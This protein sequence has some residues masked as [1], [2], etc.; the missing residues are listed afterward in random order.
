M[1]RLRAPIEL[2][3]NGGMARDH[4]IDYEKMV[5]N[6]S[7]M[8]S[9]I[10]PEDMLH[11]LTSPPEIYLAEGGMTT[12]TGNT[13]LNN[14]REENIEIINN[15][16]NRIMVSADMPLTYQ[17]RTYI[18]DVLRKVGIRDDRRFMSEVRQFMQE[19]RDTNELINI[20][21]S[22]PGQF[23][24]YVENYIEGE[25]REREDSGEEPGEREIRNFLAQS[26]LNR[27][28]TGAIYQILA[29]FNRSINETSIA[30]GEIRISE[31]AY[32]AQQILL[33]RIREAAFKEPP[34]LVYKSENV[35]EEEFSSEQRDEKNLINQVNSAV[36]L[37][38]IRNLY[39]SEFDRIRPGENRWFEFKEVLYNTSQNTIARL[40]G[41]TENVYVSISSPQSP[42]EASIT[43]REEE[44]PVPGEETRIINEGDRL[45][46][47][48]K[49]VLS[50]TSQSTMT[51]LQEKTENAY[52]NISSPEFTEEASI[53]L[54]EEEI[55]APGEE[56]RIISEDERLVEEL[57]RVERINQQ[58]VGRYH[59][60]MEL[61]SRIRQ[62]E[63]KTGGALKT[64]KASLGALKGSSEVLSRLKGEE[65]EGDRLRREVFNEV[66]KLFPDN[67]GQI[68]SVIEQYI[69]EGTISPDSGMSIV[70]NDLSTL[71]ADIERAEHESHTQE[72]I[73][74][75]TRDASDEVQ[76]T[77]ERL[78]RQ[79]ASEIQAG[80]EREEPEKVGLIHR[81][82]ETLSAEEINETLSQM[83]Q[84]INRTRVREETNVQE[85]DESRTV[86]RQTTGTTTTITERDRVD[87]ADLVNQ[88]VQRQVGAISEEVMRK[89]EKR[90]GNEK[91]RRG[92]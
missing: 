31:Q 8:A 2:K 16:L 5:A 63:K 7:L 23:R 57:K 84:D 28:Q 27:L 80:R 45:T 77:L 41:S 30:G 36:F 90:L 48:L 62:T 20:F 72:L 56:T 38:L 34:E 68:L 81:R 60:M 64:K 10:T 11:V 6:Y 3:I 40:Q 71:V 12:V 17:D 49:E 26:V 58:N 47:E 65:E 78:N 67:S 69:E 75:E 91:S 18:S 39:H 83:R 76:E 14:R 51:R 79:E 37:D 4:A 13:F 32:T 54:R 50:K 33:S 85:R 86:K 70:R 43:F 59:R 89:L 61:I 19:T 35:Y 29:N 42:G 52:V 92:I 55:P 53:T 66:E 1:L 73:L 82:E 46:E 44:I 87:I 21:L 25:R 24:Q 22:R 88:G 74:R 9:D 15:V